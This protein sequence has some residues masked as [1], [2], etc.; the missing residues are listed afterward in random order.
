M[1]SPVIV[2]P[3]RC[4]NNV[5]LTGHCPAGSEQVAPVP[6][7]LM[8]LVKSAHDCERKA[9]GEAKMARHAK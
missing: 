3:L 6:E 1:E 8:Q 9:S 4:T 5:V 7:E 2:I